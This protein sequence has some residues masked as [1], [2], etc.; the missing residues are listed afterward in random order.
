MQNGVGEKKQAS[1][2]VYP[3]LFPISPLI[4]HL[5]KCTN[6]LCKIRKQDLF[7]IFFL[8]NYVDLICVDGFVYVCTTKEI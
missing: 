7:M 8:T 2:Y 4:I 1:N 5:N 6:Q 3:R